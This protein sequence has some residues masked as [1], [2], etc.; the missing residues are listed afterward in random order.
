MNTSKS[1]NEAYPAAGQSRPAKSTFTIGEL[2]HAAGVGRDTIR[3][4]E[5]TGLIRSVQ[6][7]AAGYRIYERPDLSRILFIRSAQR[8]GFTLGETQSLLSLQASDTALASDV[9]TLTLAKI[10]QAQDKVNDLN[11]IRAILEG[12]VEVCPRDTGT[13]DCPILAFIATKQPANDAGPLA[14]A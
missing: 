13:G 10:Q 1:L 9:L 5:R 12:L 4:Y 6:R 8:L 3:Y 11:A 2:A 7:T 14:A